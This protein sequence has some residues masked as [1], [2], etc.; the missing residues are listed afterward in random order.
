MKTE[1]SLGIGLLP[2]LCE[3][4]NTDIALHMGIMSKYFHAL[5][6]KILRRSL[7]VCRTHVHSEERG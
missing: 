1:S 6:H 3:Y 5:T 7:R 4:Q 2:H